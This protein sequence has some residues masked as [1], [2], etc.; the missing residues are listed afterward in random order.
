M[1]QIHFQGEQATKPLRWVGWA[2]N[3]YIAAR[4]MLLENQLL[5][6][7]GLSNM[8]I[9][10][11][12]KTFLVILNLK[13][14]KGYQGHNVSNLYETLKK[15]GLALELNEEYLALLFKSYGLRYPDKLKPGDNI[16]LCR[17]KLLVELDH[18]V[19]EIRKCMSFEKAGKKIPTHIEY[20]QEKKDPILL[21]KNCYFGDCDKVTLFNEISPCR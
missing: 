20:L 19:Y 7:S 6:G 4:Q 13:F 3:D 17:T 16:L 10:K 5:P 2:D 8:A 14:P 9:E 18:T 11:Y 15:E 1:D 21:N 12:L